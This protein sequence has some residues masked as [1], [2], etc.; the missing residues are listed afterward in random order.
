MMLAGFEQPSEGKIT[1]KGQSIDNLLPHQRN[2]GVVFQDYALFPHLTVEQNL[3]YPLRYRSISKPEIA[4]RIATTLDMLELSQ[5]RGRFP[6]QLSGGQQQRV[7]LGRALIFNPHL[8]LM[9]EPLGALDRQLRERMQIEIKHIHKKLGL[10]F[11]S[12]THDQSEALTMSDRIAVFKDGVLQQVGTP[13][14]LYETPAN[15]FVASFIGDSNFLAGNV[16]MAS[17]DYCTVNCGEGLT[18]TAKRVNS[19]GPGTRA[20]ISVRPERVTFANSN[21]PATDKNVAEGH[22]LEHIYLGDTLRV[23]L[24]V[25]SSDDFLIK[26]AAGDASAIPGVGEAVRVVWTRAHCSAYLPANP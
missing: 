25:G 18:I 17:D 1:F 9:D 14:A 20:V 21:R 23:R 22:V 12:V 16:I 13:L 15:S 4:S 26:L 6:K 3:A 19:D 7:A 2:F 10:T 11:V 24:R 5:F 8:V